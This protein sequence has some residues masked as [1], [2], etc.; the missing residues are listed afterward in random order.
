MLRT[1]KSDFPSFRCGFLIVTTVLLMFFCTPT[2]VWSEETVRPTKDSA[3]PEIRRGDTVFM[4]D[5]P[6]HYEE[7]QITALGWGGSLANVERAHKSGV[8]MFAASVGFRTEISGMIDYCEAKYG[9]EA[10]KFTE[11]QCRDLDGNPFIVPWLWDHQHKGERAWHFCSNAPLFREYLVHRA[12]ETAK[13]GVDGLHVDDYTGTAG[14]AQWGDGCFCEYC[15]KLYREDLIRRQTEMAQTLTDVGIPLD[16]LSSFDYGTFLRSRGVNAKK[17]KTSWRDQPLGRDFVDFQYRTATAFIGEYHRLAEEAAGRPLALAVNSG[18]WSPLDLV[19]APHLTYFC[20]EVSQQ[21]SERKVP[22]HPIAVYKLADALSR[23]MTSTASGQDW[24]FINENHEESL[25]RSWTVL[26]YVFGHNFMAPERQWCYTE[27]KGTH[28]YRAPKGAYAD[29]YRFVH[30][31]RDLFDGY[32][33]VAPMAVL[34]DMPARLQWKADIEPA[35]TQLALRNMPFEVVVAGNEWL[36]QRITETSLAKYQV[37]WVDPHWQNSPLDAAQKNVL[38]TLTDRSIDTSETPTTQILP[39]TDEQFEQFVT[40]ES[41]QRWVLRTELA[42]GTPVMTVGIVPRQ[43]EGTSK[44]QKSMEKFTSN[45]NR[46][47]ESD[48]KEEEEK[49]DV[50]HLYNRNYDAATKD[51]VPCTGLTLRFSDAIFPGKVWK[52]ATLISPDTPDQIVTVERDT[53]GFRVSIPSLKL[54]TIVVLK[55]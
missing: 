39:W 26:S 32:D 13:S 31:H 15:M 55:P 5:E 8:R 19:I 50:I 4:Y 18:M 46:A 49:P 34:F 14:P 35:V 2:H 21:A 53:Q 23:P 33:A 12:V 44:E 11:A 3:R 48:G 16:S 10:K 9:T 25:V 47:T 40:N 29:L 45:T 28:W 22:T 36:P 43:Y 54:W 1:K 51:F 20:G 52:T 24:A 27:E 7:Y 17:Y 38:E 30:E 42:D 37:V 41:N 6:E